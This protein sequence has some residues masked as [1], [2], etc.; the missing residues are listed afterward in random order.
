MTKA[1]Y[2]AST[3]DCR[4]TSIW[5]AVVLPTAGVENNEKAGTA[6]TRID[7]N[8]FHGTTRIEYTLGAAGH[9]TLEIFDISGGQVA[10]LVDG[11]MQP[12]AH[13]A[14]WDASRLPAG[15]YYCRLTVG[16]WS[17]AQALIVR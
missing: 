12:G 7:P 8:P 4:D 13:A 6:L 2:W 5:T 11:E 14:T 17:T 10:T 15:T 3:R 1:R 9:A 16:E